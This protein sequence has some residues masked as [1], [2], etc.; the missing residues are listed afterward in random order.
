[1]D[2]TCNSACVP[3]KSAFQARFASS[4]GCMLVA[5]FA[6]NGGWHE[7]VGGIRA[8]TMGCQTA[9]S[10]HGRSLTCARQPRGSS[11]KG[12]GM[13]EQSRV[14]VMVSR[15]AEKCDHSS[16]VPVVLQ[17]HNE[18]SSSQGTFHRAHHVHCTPPYIHQYVSFH[19]KAV[20][21]RHTFK[22]IA[23]GAPPLCACP[24]HWT[25]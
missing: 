10:K 20:R 14:M 25:A 2:S 1:M 6:S 15:F 8:G 21:V 17:Q 12:Q 22:A 11:S 13:S 9:A 24:W 4:G 23:P 18:L 19:M 5:Q 3:C 7:M 16:F